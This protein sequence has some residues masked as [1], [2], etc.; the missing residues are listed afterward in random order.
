MMRMNMKAEI[1]VETTA[2]VENIKNLVTTTNF[3]KK[4]F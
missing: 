1:N 3:V 2:K 4:A